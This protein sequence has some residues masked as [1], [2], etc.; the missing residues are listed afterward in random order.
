VNLVLVSRESGWMG[1]RGI[2]DPPL[3]YGETVWDWEETDSRYVLFQPSDIICG[4][5]SHYG[6]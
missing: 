1:I 2:R 6:H 3:Y 4:R 5:H